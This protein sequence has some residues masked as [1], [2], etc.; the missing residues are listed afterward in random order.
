MILMLTIESKE[1]MVEMIYVNLSLIGN[2]E[3]QYHL[4]IN[5]S[6]TMLQLSYQNV[7]RIEN[8]NNNHP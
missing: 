3:I 2:Y 7:V 8:S 1:Y 6:T 5:Y 4:E